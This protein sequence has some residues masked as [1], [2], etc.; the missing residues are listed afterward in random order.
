M[1]GYEERLKEIK[2]K[3][4]KK[5]RIYKVLACVGCLVIGITTF[6]MV[7]PAITM[8]AQDDPAAA[9]V[10]EN[11]AATEGQ[12]DAFLNT[13][14]DDGEVDTEQTQNPGSVIPEDNSQDSGQPVDQNDDSAMND[15]GDSQEQIPAENDDNIQSLGAVQED[16]VEPAS[17]IISNIIDNSETTG[18][19]PS[20]IQEFTF[21]VR[22]KS[23][24]ELLADQ[25]FPYVM[26]ET[27]GMQLFDMNGEAQITL[28][29]GESIT[30]TQ[31]PSDTT[32]HVVA[33]PCAGYLTDHRIDGGQLI[34]GANTG[35]QSLTD[36]ASVEYINS[37]ASYTLPETGGTGTTLIILM[38][39]LLF[40]GAGALL[41]RRR[42]SHEA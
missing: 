11:N 15:S 7:T 18:E 1:N 35:E 21:T 36:S 13:I 26:G 14:E 2:E 37:E 8:E 38:G 23:G 29:H 34:D 22:L 16:N 3:H 40:I 19:E 9:A 17:L 31:L 12:S 41:L 42:M 30:I 27:S 24:M 4:K 10:I 28:K 39:S 33:E 20:E 6:A 32:W 25:E 5:K